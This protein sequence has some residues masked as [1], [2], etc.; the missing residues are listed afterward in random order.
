M[1]G[2]NVLLNGA[3]SLP[4]YATPNPHPSRAIYGFALF[5]CSWLILPLYII[6]AFVP[7][8]WLEILHIT[9]IPAKYWAIAIPLLFPTTV[10]AFVLLIFSINLIRFHGIFDN[11]EVV[12]YDFGEPSTVEGLDLKKYL[13]RST[14]T[15]VS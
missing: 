10:T 15:N 9:Y 4:E 3:G 5:L 7:T 11:V 1:T 13:D 6:W 12:E 2:E 14:L 8:P